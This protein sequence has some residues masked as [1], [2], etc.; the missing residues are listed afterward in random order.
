MA[1]TSAQRV[2][3][4]TQRQKA[5]IVTFY[6]EPRDGIQGFP[7]FAHQQPD[8]EV[9]AEAEVVC[10]TSTTSKVSRVYDMLGLLLT[11]T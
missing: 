2:P 1:S 5:A 8:D 9:L 10:F 7:V 11:R 4:M 6:D 3:F